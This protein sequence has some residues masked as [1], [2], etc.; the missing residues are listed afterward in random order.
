MEWIAEAAL[1]GSFFLFPFLL[2]VLHDEGYRGSNAYSAFHSNHDFAPLIVTV[3]VTVTFIRDWW[4]NLRQ[5]WTFLLTFVFWHTHGTT[6]LTVIRSSLPFF[7][8]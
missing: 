8:P 6:N 2:R 5:L 3:T 7:S 4:L 1:G